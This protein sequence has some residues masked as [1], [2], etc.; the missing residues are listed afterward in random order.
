MKTNVALFIYLN[1]GIVITEY[2]IVR[3]R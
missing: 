3:S 1:L 2:Q